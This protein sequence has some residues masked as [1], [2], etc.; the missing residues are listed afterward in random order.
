MNYEKLNNILEIVTQIIT[1]VGV[2]TAI[3]VYIKTKRREKQEREYLA[4][5]S[6]DEKHIEFLNLCLQN[7]DLNLYW[8]EEVNLN[9]IGD[10]ERGRRLILYE[11]LITN[12]ERAFLLYRNQSKSIRHKQWEG[13]NRYA[14]QWMKVKNFRDSWHSLTDNQYDLDFLDYMNSIYHEAEKNEGS[15][16]ETTEDAIKSQNK[17]RKRKKR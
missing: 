12:L 5:D 6:V 16:S 10:E 13:W 4:Y 3:F 15:S 2:P 7:A 14:I 1:I 17:I 11:I 8:G 9:S